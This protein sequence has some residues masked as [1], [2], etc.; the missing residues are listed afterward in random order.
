M[1]INSEIMMNQF[2][3]SLEGLGLKC[4]GG[5]PKLLLYFEDDEE[6]MYKLWV[7]NGVVKFCSTGEESL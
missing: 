1:S 7:Q 2:K 5:N 6:N 3:I 4:N